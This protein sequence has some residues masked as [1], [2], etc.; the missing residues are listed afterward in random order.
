MHTNDPVIASADIWPRPVGVDAVRKSFVP[1]ND[2]GNGDRGIWFFAWSRR[3]GI[4][5]RLLTGPILLA[6]P[7]TLD[8][9]R[10]MARTK[11]TALVTKP[12]LAGFK[13]STPD[14]DRKIQRSLV[15][16]L[17][18][19]DVVPP[20]VWDSP[21]TYRD[22]YRKLLYVVDLAEPAAVCSSSGYWASAAGRTPAGCRDTASLLGLSAPPRRP[23]HR[24][25]VRCA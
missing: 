12:W 6:Q 9:F 24:A 17:L 5:V 3:R 20:V 1:Q 25:Q 13:G 22:L 16:L 23:M 18:A 19:H 4:R 11:S 7:R 15:G 14:L 2:V 21:R 10:A 8:E